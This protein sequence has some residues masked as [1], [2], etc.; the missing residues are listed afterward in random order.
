MN[1]H[2]IKTIRQQLGLSQKELAEKLGVKRLAIARWE[3][4][5]RTPD[6]ANQKRLG[7]FFK[8]NGLDTKLENVSSN[9]ENVSTKLDTLDTKLDTLDTKNV[10]KLDTKSEN[11]SNEVDTNNEII[12]K[13]DTK[14]DIKTE[15]VSI[16][17]KNVTGD[18]EIVSH[19]DTPDTNV[20]D[21]NVSG[22]QDFVSP[23]DT[24]SELDTNDPV[25][26]YYETMYSDAKG[27]ISLCTIPQQKESDD[28]PSP[29]T[30]G[31]Y[32]ISQIPSLIAKVEQWNGKQHIYTGVHPLKE[33]PEK[34]RGKEDD[35]LGVALLAPDV[36]AKDFIDDAVEKQKANEEKAFF[37]WT[38][39]LLSECKAKALEHIRSVCDKVSLPPT[40]IIDSGHGYY[41]IFKL[42][43]FM[44][45]GND[46]HRE[47]LK[48]LNKTLH[49]V[50]SADSTF[51]FAR[52]LR[53]PGTR[54][55]K[56]GYPTDCNL[57]EF[58]PDR[59]Y[60]IDDIRRFESLITK[61]EPIKQK[62]KPK[63]VSLDDRTLINKAMN[64]S[65]GA[66]FTALWGG[67]IS[68][69]EN[70]HSDADCAL[71]CLLA[72][73]TG[74]DRERIDRLF[75]QSG[76]YRDKWD[77]RNEGGE[78][79]YKKLTID[80]ALEQV[81]E[82]YDPLYRADE[83]FDKVTIDEP[84]SEPIPDEV[85]DTMAEEASKTTAQEV[86]FTKEE[87]KNILATIDGKLEKTDELSSIEQSEL[88][89]ET[90]R[91][92][93]QLNKADQARYIKLLAEKFNVT[94]K[95][96]R[97]DMKALGAKDT[98][99]P[100]G[101]NFGNIYELNGY[102]AKGNR[103]LGYLKTEFPLQYM[104]STFI[105][106]PKSKLWIDGFEAIN[107]T[108]ISEHEPIEDV[109]IERKNWNSPDAFMEIIPSTKMNFTGDRKDV[110][111]IMLIVSSYDVPTQIAT[112]QVGW[113]KDK[114][115]VAPNLNL[116]QEGKI[117]PVKVF[118][119][120][121]GGSN[122]IDSIINYDECDDNHFAELQSHAKRLLELNETDVTIPIIGWFHGTL[123]KR[124][125]LNHPNFRHFPHLN[126]A[127]SRG[128]GK[129]TLAEIF[130][131]V[132][133]WTGDALINCSMTRFALLRT[134][135]ATHS[136]PTVLDEFKPSNMPEDRVA[137]IR[138]FMRQSYGGT[139]DQRGRPDQSIVEYHLTAPIC[140]VGE[141]PYYPLEAAAIERVIPV[142]TNFN[143][144]NPDTEQ[145][146]RRAEL[147]WDLQQVDW[148][149][150]L[151]KYIRYLT[152]I[153]VDEQIEFAREDAV[154]YLGDRDVPRRIWDNLAAMIFG[155]RQYETF[156]GVE[157]NNFQIEHAI[158][159]IVTSLCGEA[160]KR[161]K[162]AFEMALEQMAV[163]AELGRLKKEIHYLINESNQLCLRLSACLSEFRRFARETSWT[164][165]ILDDNA[166]RKQIAEIHEEGRL[167]ISPTR[168]VR[169]WQGKRD[170]I[171][172]AVVIQDSETSDVDLSGFWVAKDWDEV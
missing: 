112:Q 26:A 72:F 124:W 136:F 41:P 102:D 129:S 71:C 25:R 28:N 76:L 141:A 115:W 166:Y 151:P 164:G 84:P 57:L 42:D 37:R 79:D 103:E 123:T 169:G 33:K 64:A 119:Y 132:F 10:S 95:A 159:T 114:T 73:W 4:G 96:L 54:N 168:T 126:I 152:T 59:R 58:H 85:L 94:Q 45:F 171:A 48:K 75:R 98:T 131:Q 69:Y 87:Y 44:E 67:D 29:R 143:A 153:N 19:P 3:S 122:V 142:H 167:I 172:R 8:A 157:V 139:I 137:N 6:E 2:E 20:S 162:L 99:E 46:Q 90:L 154:R 47:D 77:R 109:V 9:D 11:V 140:L 89:Q 148:T 12:S 104:I 18:S 111:N 61:P 74:G 105:I 5:T 30:Q 113:H 86:S 88:I 1:E 49:E 158:Q 138:E 36:D 117:E 135:S 121:M 51:D 62:P 116:N 101:R 31:F 27:F 23:P 144:I 56:P 91:E 161:G 83:K 15:S 165:E 155:V 35:I 108:F 13:L 93:A 63:A 110:Q 81:T 68:G 170:N 43:K 156:T 24:K 125:W 50:F 7:Q 120:P 53:V 107:A 146:K 127:G 82:F 21:N 17:D 149:G 65:D 97:D 100:E 150:Y 147:C 128:S 66:K 145:G 22:K 34:G 133:G 163:M 130:W 52:I 92:I 40:A 32:E 14:L 38:D 118:Y 160:G 106:E 55:I 39:E 70:D 16:N 134:F 80:A 78:E 60:T